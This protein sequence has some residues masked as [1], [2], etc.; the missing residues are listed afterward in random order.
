MARVNFLFGDKFYV[1]IIFQ[2]IKKYGLAMCSV[3]FRCT[4]FMFDF[5]YTDLILFLKPPF[6][7][8][9]NEVKSQNRDKHK[10]G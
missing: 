9:A 7:I 1:Q 8:L 2:A 3:G 5:L 6:G 10:P 4:Y